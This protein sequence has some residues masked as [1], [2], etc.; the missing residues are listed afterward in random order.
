MNEGGDITAAARPPWHGRA[1]LLVDLDAFFASVEQLDHP[2]WRGK[3]VI[4]GGA[5]E[6]RGVVSTC[7]YEAR[8]F[9]VHSAM[10]SAQARRLCPGAIWA[11]ARF[12]R[13]RE[14]SS[15]V[16][17]ILL[18]ESPLLEQMSID[19]AYLDV[20]PGRYID[21][22]PVAIAARIQRRVAELGV[23][24][25]VGVASGKAVAKIASDMDK[26]RGLTVVYPGGE[27]A[28][29]APLDVQELPGIGGKSAAKLKAQGIRTLGDLAAAPLEKLQPVFGV[30]ARSVK[31][32]AGGVDGRE[33]ETEGDAKSVSNERTFAEDLVS[34][35]QIEDAID[36][37]GSLVGRRL[38]RKGLAGHTVTLKLRYSDLS[39]R[40]AQRTLSRNVDDE[41][42]FIPVAKELVDEI[43][44][45]GDSVRLVGVGVSGFDEHDRQLG[46]FD[47]EGDLPEGKSEL[48]SA[49][50][51]V[52]DR[53][54]DDALKFGREL[55]FKA[56]T[57]GAGEGEEEVE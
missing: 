23:T 4:V 30:N 20:T 44:K 51:R 28:F 52:R 1:I 49:A 15:Q 29:L 34:R 36:Y 16:M 10:P 9:G 39:R 53:F 50:D 31:E 21:E 3:P 26:P 54:G 27:A 6:R 19:E 25:S 13:Y 24:C 46:L 55:K 43:W 32:R 33:I 11:P 48:V 41:A 22:S 57:S 42:V 40:S 56:A 8:V 35:E 17:A 7:S 38:R 47:E 14:V 37:I 18:D 12:E 5:A 45:P 2:E